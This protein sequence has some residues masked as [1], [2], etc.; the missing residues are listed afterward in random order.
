MRLCVCMCLCVCMRLCVHVSV[1]VCIHMVVLPCVFMCV[2]VYVNLCSK[3][4]CDVY[5]NPI[6]IY[7]SFYY[8]HECKVLCKMSNVGTSHFLLHCLQDI[9]I[10]N[11]GRFCL[12]NGHRICSK[13]A[14][15]SGQIWQELR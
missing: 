4:I 12:Q 8:V 7:I 1:C 11:S 13:L 3:N 15:N 5:K 9:L 6:Y 10:S 2:T 14:S